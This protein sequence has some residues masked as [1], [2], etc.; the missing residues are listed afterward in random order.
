M[1]TELE[2][3]LAQ[4]ASYVLVLTV[5]TIAAVVFI[6]SELPSFRA[7]AL[8]PG[9][10]ITEI[11]LDDIATVGN[12]F[13]MQGAYWYRQLSIPIPF[14]GS[15]IVLHHLLLFMDR[16]SFVFGAAVLSLIFFR[17]LPE[18]GP[19]VDTFLIARRGLLVTV[20]LFALFALRLNWSDSP[21]HS[22]ADET[23]CALHPISEFLEALRDFGDL[24]RHAG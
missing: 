14:L 6:W 11:P 4:T 22:A 19:N 2:K 12:L 21:M 23:S 18:L 15:N 20:S 9:N 5:Q 7:L 1:T 16:L 3:R 24:K 13:V 17:H 8:N 10:R